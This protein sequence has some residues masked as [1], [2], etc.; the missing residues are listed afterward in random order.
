MRPESQVIVF[1]SIHRVL[2]TILGHRDKKLILAEP[3]SCLVFALVS[4]VIIHAAFASLLQGILIGAVYVLTA[5]GARLF[6]EERRRLKMSIIGIVDFTWVWLMASMLG[7]I[8]FANGLPVVSRIGLV[9]ANPTPESVQ[10]A[11]S[12]LQ[13]LFGRVIDVVLVMGSIVAVCMSIIWSGE[14]W[15]KKTKLKE[16]GDTTR[17]SLAIVTAFMGITFST[18]LWVLVPM[19][20][21]L[22]SLRGML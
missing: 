1:Y 2:Y 6:D 5:I 10:A 14:V 16:Y 11:H 4:V 13:F 19:Y 18:F 7:L 15:R 22:E 9:E 12:E 3:I 20:K 8:I 21:T 17:A